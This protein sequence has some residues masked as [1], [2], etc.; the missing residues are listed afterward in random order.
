MQ[1]VTEKELLDTFMVQS[2]HSKVTSW[3]RF[4]V[5]NDG[6]NEFMGTLTWDSD[7]GYKMVW[8][9]DIPAM[10]ERPEFEYVLDSITNGRRVPQY[11]D[12]SDAG[13]DGA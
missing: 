7:D 13:M 6:D 4:V 11:G 12:L 10:S 3:R 8:W 9:N 1:E 2:E 5:L